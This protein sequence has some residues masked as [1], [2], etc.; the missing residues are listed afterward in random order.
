[1]PAEVAAGQSTQD[2]PPAIPCVIRIAGGS[3]KVVSI[4]K[5]LATACTTVLLTDHARSRSDLS[6]LWFCLGA[7]C[8]KERSWSH[9]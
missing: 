8:R 1:M 4:R 5:A 9:R 7:R 2:D 6:R 3:A